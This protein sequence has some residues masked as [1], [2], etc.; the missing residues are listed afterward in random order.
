MLRISLEQWRMFRAVVEFGGF[1]QAS[2]HIYKSQ[3][4]IHN[5][6]GK[7]E[8]SLGVKLFSIEGRK[9]ILTEA[10]T[11]MLRRANFLLDEAAKVEEVGFTLGQGT[12]SRLRIAIDEVFPQSILF[13]V[14]ENV[15]LQYPLLQI[16][17]IET[18]LNG[19]TEL[20]QNTQVDIAISPTSLS[21]SL[22]EDLYKIEFIAVASPTH[23]LHK[24]ERELTLEDLKSQRQIVVRD[25][26]TGLKKSEGWLGAN[27]R[28]TVSHI[29]TS[30]EMIC[31]GLG[32]AWLSVGSI[33]QQLADGTLKPLRLP[34]NSKRSAQ[35]YLIFKDAD[36]LGPAAQCFLTELRKECLSLNQ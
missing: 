34:H 18:I 3:S 12:E 7:I 35:L 9:T 33:E 1:N 30:I 28:W 13:K 19:S 27:Q 5:A 25:S 24:L 29:Q 10:G 16:E 6:V 11:L 21:G 23:P 31:K 8:S 4:S 14:L 2:Q 15:S 17:L 22:S 32:F 26:A 20:L 36:L